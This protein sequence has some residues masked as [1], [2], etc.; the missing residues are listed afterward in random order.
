MQ[1]MSVITSSPSREKKCKCGVP[2]AKLTSWTRENP[3]RKFRTCKFYDPVTES[4]GCK[5]FEWVDEP[6]GTAWQ[7]EVINNLLLDKKLLKGEITDYKREVDDLGG[8]MRCLLNEVDSLK[9][10]CKAINS[11]RKK[12][13]RDLNG[14]NGRSEQ[15]VVYVVVGISFVMLVMLVIGGFVMLKV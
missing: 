1:E 4:K 10:K 13:N 12:M 11:D 14:R 5:S 2:L 7:T 3:G 15:S 8:Q 6:D 9:M